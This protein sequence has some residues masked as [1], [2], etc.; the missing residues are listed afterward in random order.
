MMCLRLRHSVPLVLVLLGVLP[1]TALAQQGERSLEQRVTLLERKLDASALTSML[2]TVEQLRSELQRLRGEVERLN[3]EVEDMQ[4]RQRELYVDLDTRIREL[5]TAPSGGA[6]ADTPPPGARTPPADPPA[7]PAGTGG[8]GSPPPATSGGSQGGAPADPAAE[9]RRY[10]QALQTLRDGRYAEASQQLQA[11]LESYPNGRLADNA[12]YWLGE[13]Y[14]V[15]RRFEP[16]MA[17][18]QR[19]LEDFPDSAKRPDALL[20]IGY[21]QFEQG[22]LDAARETLNEVARRY[23]DSTAA[24]LAQQRLRRL[25]GG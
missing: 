11:F 18:F 16:A 1:G 5:Q 3:R 13:S 17:E 25:S 7:P 9:S 6:S 23:P 21:I 20:K 15:V 19:V 8:G 4:S 12:R 10:Q 24:T 14:Y 2:N 22:K